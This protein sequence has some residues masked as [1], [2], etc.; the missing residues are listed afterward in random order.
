MNKYSEWTDDQVNIEV[1][2]RYKN[3]CFYNDGKQ[4]ARVDYCNDWGNAGPITFENK[5]DVSHD[6]IFDEDSNSIFWTGDVEAQGYTG[7]SWVSGF[8]KNP[9]RAAM[10]VYLMMTESE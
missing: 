1:H 3:E 10:E 9:L 4:V 6:S 5:I 8:S 7:G 2:K